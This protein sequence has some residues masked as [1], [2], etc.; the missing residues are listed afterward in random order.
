MEC[1][2]S[3]L[4]QMLLGD[5]IHCIWKSFV[6]DCM[7]WYFQAKHNATHKLF[8]YLKAL[9]EHLKITTLDSS[10]ELYKTK[11]HKTTTAKNSESRN[12]HAALEPI[13]FNAAN[14]IIFRLQLHPVQAWGNGQFLRLSW[15]LIFA[16]DFFLNYTQPRTGERGTNDGTENMI[17]NSKSAFSLPESQCYPREEFALWHGRT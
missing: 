7:I 8:I 5:K 4:P 3:F 10:Q 1:V 9:N 11:H 15:A 13:P 2:N 17:S 6:K 14:T 16:F 12:K